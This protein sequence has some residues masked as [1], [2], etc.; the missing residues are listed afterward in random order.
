LIF[1]K[2][3]RGDCP[4]MDETWIGDRAM[5]E[6]IRT[7]MAPVEGDHPGDDALK[8]LGALAG[9][10]GAGVIGITACMHPPYFYFEA[11]AVALE[12]YQQDEQRLMER[13]QDA[14]K[15]FR[16]ALADVQ[17]PV[18]WRS[19]LELPLDYV[20][21]ESR[22]ADLVVCFQRGDG[23]L[24]ECGDPGEVVLK[25]G[26]PVLAVPHGVACGV[27][28]KVVIAWKDSR[29]SRRAVADAL[30]LLRRATKVSVVEALEGEESRE[31]AER[32]VRD[33]AA[34]LD[35][36]SIPA[37]AQV[38]T[39]RGGAAAELETAS[40]GVDL[41]VAGAY[42]HSRLG[43]WIFGGVTRHLLKNSACPVFLSH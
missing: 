37:S 8:S 5:S 1:R 16:S 36:H 6:G 22:A 18:H 43:E 25:A 12:A 14:E 32:R 42:G 27:P 19:A 20:A 40:Q 13:M 39:G 2:A 23:R 4:Q 3:L 31:S 30:P 10:L 38:L 15:R 11:G 9:E 24:L 21:R 17:G 33:V 28:R 35:A 7:L 29:E 26:R 41:I 34:W